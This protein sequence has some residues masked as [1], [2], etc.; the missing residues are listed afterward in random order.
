MKAVSTM[1]TATIVI[2]IV[3]IALGAP[4]KP[5]SP[6]TPSSQPTQSGLQT[7]VATGETGRLS[8][9]LANVVVADDLN[10]LNDLIKAAVSEGDSGIAMI[11]LQGRAFLVPQWTQVRV[12]GHAG[13]LSDKTQV[14]ILSGPNRGR[15]GWVPSEFVKP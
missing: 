2:V 12:I 13:F 11:I 10:A 4:H 9:G 3:L 5:S 8:T 7:T 14:R 6:S 15:S 1:V